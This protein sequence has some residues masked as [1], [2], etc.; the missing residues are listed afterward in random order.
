MIG[1]VFGVSIQYN[2]D[3][4]PEFVLE[5]LKY[6]EEHC[7]QVEGLFRISADNNVLMEYKEKIDKGKQV[8]FNEITD[9]HLI[10]GNF[11]FV[12]L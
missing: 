11:F 7:L 12:K 3:Q 8:K 1:K 4:L 6:L 2:T 5:C 9:V 10:S